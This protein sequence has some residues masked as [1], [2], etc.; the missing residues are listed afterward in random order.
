MEK[1]WI[2]GNNKPVTNS[3]QEILFYFHLLK[4]LFIF[5]LG[6]YIDRGLWKVQII[7]K[8]SRICGYWNDYSKIYQRESH[9]NCHDAIGVS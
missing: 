4:S 1:E 2:T 8:P 6:W 7:S 9:F 3:N 5:F